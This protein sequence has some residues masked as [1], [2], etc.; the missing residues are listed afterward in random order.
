MRY[1]ED[2]LLGGDRDPH[3]ETED[4]RIAGASRNSMHSKQQ[5]AKSIR[6]RS[7]RCRRGF[8]AGK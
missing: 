7:G 5:E 6:R 8:I 1:V 4:E 2:S 3:D